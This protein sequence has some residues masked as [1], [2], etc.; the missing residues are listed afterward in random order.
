[1]AKPLARGSLLLATALTV[2]STLAQT[3][4]NTATAPATPDPASNEVEIVGPGISEITVLGRREKDIQKANTQVISVLSNDDIARTGE[5]DIAGALSRVTGLSVVGG[6][7]VYVRGLGDR[8]SQAL[9]NGSPLPSPEPLRRAIPLDIFPT[10]I[11]AS[12]LVQKT[13]SP[14]FPG[15]FGGGVINLTTLAIPETSFLNVSAGASANTET[16]GKLGYTYYGSSSDWTGYDSGKRDMPTALWSF[17]QSRER[18]SAGTIDSGALAAQFATANNA[19]VQRNKDIPANGSGSVTGGT[20]WTLGESRLGLVGTIGFDNGWRT[21]DNTEQSPASAD[22]STVDKDYRTV[23]TENRAVLNALLGL[24][25]EFGDHNIRWTNLYVHDTLK[26]AA[27]SAGRQ[28]NQQFGRDFLEQQTAWYERQLIDTQLA[29]T[30]KI[31]PAQLNARA[32]YATSSR[33]AP[34][35]LGFGYVRTN[36]AASPYGAYYVNRLDNGQTGF[37]SAAFSQLDEDLI[38]GGLDATIP[39]GDSGYVVTAGLDYTRTERDSTRRQFQIIAPSTFPTGVGLLRPDYLL[40]QSIVDTFDIGLVETTE[41]DPAFTARLETQAAFAQLQA[42]LFDNI[43][44]SAGAR[45]ERGEQNVSAVQVF[46]TPAPNSPTTGLEKDYVLPAATL[47]W[48]FAP[49]MQARFSASSTITRPQF[50]ELIFQAYFDPENNRSFRGNP[51][52]VDSK[53]TNGE[54]RWEWYFAEQQRLSVAGFYKKIDRPI[55]AFT[56]FNDNNPV[57]SFANAPQATLYGAE[58][59]LQKYFPLDEFAGTLPLT[60]FLESRKAVLIGNYTYTNSELKV[61]AGDIVR[62]FGTSAQPASNFFFDG[63][64]LTGQ[65]DHLVNLQLGLENSGRLSQQTI[66]FSYASDRVTSRGAAG[67]PDIYEKP[68]VTVDVVAREGFAVW[69]QAL[70]VKFEARNILGREFKEFQERGAN[71]VYYNR[72]DIGTT[73]SL[74]LTATF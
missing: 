48:K 25:F 44:L 29:G 39:L 64:P 37:G 38:S 45:F 41:N 31:G 54:A 69:G 2:Q 55:E 17:L 56:G 3:P 23:V 24:G 73:F 30:F 16:T 7:F 20:A 28:N 35:E 1:M 33:E 21:R 74:S 47:T 68:G 72:Y 6:G 60:G 52:L 4:D 26:R 63:A 22:L 9:L 12:S 70:E 32:S 51:L 62:V 65:S 13:Y 40:R 67:L 57:T 49:T 18:L 14:N 66:L 71:R 8:Y 27:L 53:F 43:E 50:R 34:F 19:V 10:D 61:Q 46:N 59:E 58:L 11:I 15:E 42:A 5:G 36:Q